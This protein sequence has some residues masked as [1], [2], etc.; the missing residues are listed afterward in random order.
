MNT[1]KTEDLIRFLYNETSNKENLL[2]ESA[3]A[4]DFKLKE[5]YNS[6]KEAIDELKSFSLSPSEQ[7][8]NR[9]LSHL[10]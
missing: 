1:I 10:A 7:S 3:L 4:Y 5:E 9:I 2:I 8:V 6:L